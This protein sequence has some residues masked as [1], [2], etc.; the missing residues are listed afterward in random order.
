MTNYE[1]IINLPKEEMIWFMMSDMSNDNTC[2]LCIHKGWLDCKDEEDRVTCIE[3]HR[4]W[5]DREPTEEDEKLYAKAR[6]NLLVYQFNNI[7]AK[8]R[9]KY[10]LVYENGFAVRLDRSEES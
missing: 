2:P 7:D 1:R 9:L 10:H 3:G 6:H 8:E 5:L 4:Q